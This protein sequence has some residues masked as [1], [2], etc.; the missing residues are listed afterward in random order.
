VRQ[1]TDTTAHVAILTE[2]ALGDR[3]T[4]KH[5]ARITHRH[6]NRAASS[7]AVNIHVRDLGQLLNSLDPS[8]F[9]DRDLDPIAA[10][11]IEEEFSEKLA[12]D[13]WNLHVHVH[14]GGTSPTD[15][16]AALETY[17]G[18]MASSVRRA[19]R[20][21]LW[22]SH[23]MLI[24]GVVVFL[25][26]RGCAARSRESSGR[27]PRSSMKVSSS[28]RGLLSGVRRRC[29]S[30]AGFRSVASGVSTSVSPKSVCSSVRIRWR[31]P[32]LPGLPSR[33]ARR[34][35]SL[36]AHCTNEQY[37]KRSLSHAVLSLASPEDGR[38]P[39]ILPSPGKMRAVSAIMR[40]RRLCSGPAA[41]VI[42]PRRSC[43]SSAATSS[44]G[45]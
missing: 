38:M 22:S 33:R 34:A 10:E 32:G 17:Y 7:A 8:P 41:R 31:P 23:R 6:V 26:S 39:L 12:V 21:H 4:L 3:V 9:W 45:K 42:S 30:M 40:G 15:L 43:S 5:L 25:L 1:R 24:C 18:R 28:S 13:T 19:L 20:E 29:C 14:E 37:R 11:F 44:P 2:V 36:Q 35:L 27:F 16:Q